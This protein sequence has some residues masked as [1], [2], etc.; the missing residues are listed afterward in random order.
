[1]VKEA[2]EKKAPIERTADKYAK[3]FTPTILIIGLVVF[4][5]TQN[6]L[7]VAAV[8]IIA[9]PCALILSTP[10]AIVASIGNAAKKGNSHTKRR[11]LRKNG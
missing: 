5:L 1:M 4:A 2:E 8:F 9:C 6:T 11:N 10:S 3:Y 7:R